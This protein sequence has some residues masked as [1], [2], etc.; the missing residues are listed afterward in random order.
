MWHSHEYR[1][2]VLYH[3]DRWTKNC[4]SWT[5]KIILNILQNKGH[6][7]T[8]SNAQQKYWIK[9]C[10]KTVTEAMER[11]V[12]KAGEISH[13]NQCNFCHAKYQLQQLHFTISARFWSLSIKKIVSF[14]LYRKCFM[15]ILNIVNKH[16]VCVYW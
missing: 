6:L 3:L 15:C 7:K 11:R 13:R 5:T 14:S 12:M 10:D 9:F 8:K 2:F 4:S 16:V 1:V